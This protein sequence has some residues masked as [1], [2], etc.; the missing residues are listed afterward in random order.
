MANNSV[1]PRSCPL[2]VHAS[3][4]FSRSHMPITFFRKRVVPATPPSFVKFK[5]RPSEVIIGSSSS[6]P[7]SDHVPELMNA[8]PSRAETAATADPVSCDAGAITRTGEACEPSR[9]VAQGAAYP[10]R[11]QVRRFREEDD[12][13]TPVAR[14]VRD[15]NCGFGGSP[16]VSSWRW[17]IRTRSAP[18]ATS[19]TGRGLSRG[20]APHPALPIS[21]ALPPRVGR[22]C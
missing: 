13:A 7:T 15:P 4:H 16:S 1:T 19:E 9:S 2:A 11:W 18:S 3:R 8:V 10:V 17:C 22:A 14:A 6:V 21:P 5:R 20:A 12:W